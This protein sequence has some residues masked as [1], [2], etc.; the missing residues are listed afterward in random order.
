MRYFGYRPESTYGTENSS[1]TVRY[2]NM[3]KSTLDT[4][5]DPNL[6]VP[7]FEETP[8][9]VKRGLYS[10][11]GDLEIALDINS[12]SEFLYFALGSETVVTANEKYLIYAGSSRKMLSFTAYVG[13]DDG[14]PNDFEHIFYGCVITK[15]NIKLSDGLATATLS[16]QAQKDGKATLKS[17]SAI[18]IADSYP[19]AF[20]EAETEMGS[21]DLTAR[22]TSFEFELDN[23]V[24]AE[25][26]QAFG[27]MHPYKLPSS[28]KTPTIKSDVFYEGY[29]MLVKFW[30]SSSGPT[31]GTEYESYKIVFT[32][33]EENVLTLLFPKIALAT[34]SAPVEGTDEIK[35]SLE[36]K[37]LKATVAKPTGFG[38]GNLYTSI[39]ATVALASD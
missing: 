24:K 11:S 25:N 32:D 12:I 9:R 10:P 4:P 23:E 2:L 36:M 6:E 14:N 26:G 18:T 31:C 39:V 16:I 20:Y 17:E 1:E 28:G 5:K 7:T 22:T 27:S 37:V 3:G 29:D 8:N 35:Q 19:I 34:A 13:K 33:E 30:G 38:T 15:I 21:T